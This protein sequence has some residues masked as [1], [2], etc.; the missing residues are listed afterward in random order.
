[1]ATQELFILNHPFVIAQSRVA[2]GN[3][4]AR[5]N[6]PGSGDEA[7]VVSAEIIGLVPGAFL[8]GLPDDV[9][10]TGFDPAQHVIERRVRV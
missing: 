10:I 2:A 1:M 3:L 8:E 6:T 7:R 4:L 5:D 9:P